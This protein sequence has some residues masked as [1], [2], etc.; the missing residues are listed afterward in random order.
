MPAWAHFECLVNPCG[1]CDSSPTWATGATHPDSGTDGDEPFRL[2]GVSPPDGLRGCG[3]PGAC[4]P[5]SVAGA[6]RL[7]EEDPSVRAQSKDLPGVPG[8]QPSYHG[9]TS[10]A[11]TDR[12]DVPNARSYPDGQRSERAKSLSRSNLSEHIPQ[13]KP[14]AVLLFWRELLI[15]AAWE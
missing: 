4:A 13:G 7:T 6:T 5:A 2:T 15:L 1:I 11:K 14:R 12:H 8:I 9:W 3:L 10:P